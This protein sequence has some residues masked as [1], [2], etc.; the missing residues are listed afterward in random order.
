M[1]AKQLATVG[2]SSWAAEKSR[3]ILKIKNI[4]K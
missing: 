1:L 3:H 4:K 2:G